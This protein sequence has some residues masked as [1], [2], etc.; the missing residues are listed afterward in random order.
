MTRRYWDCTLSRTLIRG[1]RTRS[2]GGGVFD[3]DDDRP[4]PSMFGTMMNHS[5][6]SR[7]MSC[8][9]SHSFSQY[10]P[11][12]QVGYTIALLLSALSVP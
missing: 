4:L 1:K 8:P 9:M 2:W 11:E 7:A 10:R 12:Y 6:G 5:A 3:G